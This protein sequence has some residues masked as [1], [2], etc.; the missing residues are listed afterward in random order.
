MR[1][2]ALYPRTAI[3]DRPG[4]GQGA[5]AWI[6][7]DGVLPEAQDAPARGSE[8]AIGSPVP[9]DVP[10]ELG[11]GGGGT[12]YPRLE[13]GEQT[14]GLV[15]ATLRPTRYRRGRGRR[16]AA[17]ASW[18]P[19]GPCPCPGSETSASTSPRRSSCPRARSCRAAPGEGQGKARRIR[20]D[21][22]RAAAPVLGARLQRPRVRGRKMPSPRQAEGRRGRAG[23]PE[24]HGRDR[25]A[26][27]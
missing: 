23:P 6:C 15:P 24:R 20:V 3:P 19:P 10:A 1:A 16:R 18:R 25:R 26:P 22:D 2:I 11:G 9:G 17:G 21:A 4:D 12:Q 14:S 8:A 13:A 5:A 27:R 7:Q